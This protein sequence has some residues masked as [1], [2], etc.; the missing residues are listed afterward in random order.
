MIRA[1]DPSEAGGS[2]TA[3]TATP[4]TTPHDQVSLEE[5]QAL[6]PRLEEQVS[7]D[8]ED[9]TAR[10]RLALAFYNLDRLDE[11]QA[12]YEELLAKGEDAVVRNRLGNVLR[13][14]GDLAGAEA[15]YRRALADDPALPAPYVNL[16]ELFWRL[17]RTDEALDVLDAGASA[18]TPEARP[19]LERAAAAIRGAGG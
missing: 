14:K 15:A 9:D 2:P 13:E 19:A 3:G 7:R 10:R 8:P 18:V 11:A 16:A 12:L 17:R 5:W 4:S 6:L 1:A